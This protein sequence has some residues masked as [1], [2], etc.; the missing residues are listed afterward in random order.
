MYIF[1]YKFIVPFTKLFGREKLKQTSIN[2]IQL[3]IYTSECIWSSGWTTTK[4]VQEFVMFGVHRMILGLTAEKRSWSILRTVFQSIFIFHALAERKNY[5]TFSIGR[6]KNFI[7]AK[8]IYVQVDTPVNI[9]PT[10]ST[11]RAFLEL[12]F[13]MEFFFFFEIEQLIIK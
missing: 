6:F 8:I 3:E 7:F 13:K 9:T 1:F 4:V 2:K 5:L 12:E 11:F 10:V